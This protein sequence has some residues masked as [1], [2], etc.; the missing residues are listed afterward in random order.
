MTVTVAPAGSLDSATEMT[1]V[2]AVVPVV[3]VEVAVVVT[4]IVVITVDG[5]G[6]E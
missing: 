5:I 4:R 1:N 2:G 6:G 3:A